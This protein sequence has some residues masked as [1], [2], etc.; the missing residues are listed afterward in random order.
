MNTPNRLDLQLA[1]QVT[2]SFSLRAQLQCP[3]DSF[4]ITVLFGPSGAG[5][6]TILRFI[7]GLDRPAT[8]HIRFGQETWFDSARRIYLSPQARK[9]GFLFQQDA[10]FPHLTTRGNIEIGIRHLPRSERKQ[11]LEQ[12]IDILQLQGL[13]ER[14]PSQ[15]SGG[16]KKRVALARTLAP[17]P[18]LL[19]LDEP[20]SALDL[21]TREQVRQQLRDW[22]SPFAI[23]T[24]LVTHDRDEA[25]G[26]GDQLVI[27]DAGQT[28]QA[29]PVLD[30]LARPD[31]PTV[32]R[33]VGVETIQQA[34]VV[35]NQDGLLLLDVNGTQLRA[36]TSELPSFFTPGRTVFACIR[37][38][39]VLLER[40]ATPITSARNRLRG[41]VVRI[42]V[43]G[44]AW[45]VTIDVGFPL[46]AWVTRSAI[47]EMGLVVGTEVAALF[48]AHAVHVVGR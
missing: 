13:Q 47:D 12:L 44:A 28:M 7:A 5:K 38:E 37:G 34:R 27:V 3:I 8:G 14:K 31:N 46:A 11:R 35:S 6:T 18:R 20:F 22:L 21:P 16:E 45:K 32:A 33:I 23:P 9:I 24:L 40:G 36:A 15:L 43:Q 30:L 48:K 2:K 19:L 29:G 39:E 25:I 42:D 26:L 17:L 10:L 4:H 41:K 1:R